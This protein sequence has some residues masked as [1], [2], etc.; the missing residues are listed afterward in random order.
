MSGPPPDLDSD[1]VKMWK[2]LDREAKVRELKAKVR[3]WDTSDI[4]VDEP[5]DFAPGSSYFA[6][7]LGQTSTPV[8]L[9]KLDVVAALDAPASP[10]HTQ[11]PRER[12]LVAQLL[13]KISE[14]EETNAQFAA[15][16]AEARLRLHHAELETENVR[17]LCDFISEEMLGIA[18]VE[19]GDLELD[20]APAPLEHGGAER[21]RRVR[22]KASLQLEALRQQ[23][24][25]GECQPLRLR[26]HSSI[27]SFS[28]VRMPGEGSSAVQAGGAVAVRTARGQRKPVLRLFEN[29]TLASLSSSSGS[30]PVPT[31]RSS[32]TLSETSYG[33]PEVEL[34]F[35][36]SSSSGNHSGNG[37]EN[38][39]SSSGGEGNS[40]RMK[41]LGSELGLS[42]GGAGAG[43]SPVSALPSS[44]SLSGGHVRSRSIM[45][46]LYA[47]EGNI[48]SA[49]T[50]SGEEVPPSLSA[51]TESGS[52]TL[53]VP[54]SSPNSPL[55]PTSPTLLI[56]PTFE[57]ARKRYPTLRRK[58]SALGLSGVG[59]DIG[60][61]S[62]T[63]PVSPTFL[64]SLSPIS[65]S[66]SRP[67][68]SSIMSSD[69]TVS[70]SV[71]STSSTL[72]S[73]STPKKSKRNIYT[74]LLIDFWLWLQF[75]VIII[76][77]VI[78]MA[79][80]GPKSVFRPPTNS[81]A[82]AAAALKGR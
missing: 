78:T 34:H 49:F 67:T 41:S 13:L 45:E 40:A 29:N 17:R 25:Q 39:N 56:S 26:K 33:E 71:T 55:S 12:T 30:G 28:S 27:E 63:S 15:Q 65:S 58:P 44:A 79:R 47:A 21:L 64:S 22:R 7:K 19:E 11:T 69:H 75:G 23:Q 10:T 2:R 70:V 61:R 32:D 20:E 1:L 37:Y 53:T 60:M 31:S 48:D 72:T 42:F 51:R 68:G 3:P 52:A 35:P 59:G 16:H 18:G 5:R 74:S 50:S 54:G 82:S 77:F 81:K 62:P 66:N 14:L 43:G 24:Q 38:S 4:V 76:V 46:L 36:D 73:E 6:P 57:D 8:K 9:S 80:M